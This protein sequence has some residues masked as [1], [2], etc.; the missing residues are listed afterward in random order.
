MKIGLWE[1][2]GLLALV[3]AAFSAWLRFVENRNK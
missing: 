1:F 2:A 3:G